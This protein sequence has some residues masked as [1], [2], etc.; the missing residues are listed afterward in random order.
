MADFQIFK[1]TAL[2]QLLELLKQSL[3]QFRVVL[4]PKK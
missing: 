3:K 2:K 1:T 4:R